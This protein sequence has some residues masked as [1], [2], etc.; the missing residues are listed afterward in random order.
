MPLNHNREYSVTE[1][2]VYGHERSLILAKATEVWKGCLVSGPLRASLLLDLG[3]SML[4]RAFERLWT[5]S[6][7]EE[8]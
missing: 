5:S 8:D 1:H 2:V 3:R 7:L 4:G 6:S